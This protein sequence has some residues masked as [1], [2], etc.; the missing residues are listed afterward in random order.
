MELKDL[1]RKYEPIEKK[2]NLPSF[3]QLNIDFEIEK[4]TVESDFL[5]RV[6][7][8][9]MMDKIIGFLNFFEK[10]ISNPTGMPR[11]YYPFIKSIT[12]EDRKEMEKIYDDMGALSLESLELE[13]ITSEKA[14][15]KMVKKIYDCWEKIKQQ[16][17]NLAEKMKTSDGQTIRKEKS[18][19]G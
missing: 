5:L 9:I 11:V 4:I 12:V 3:E 15:A 8:K 1:K 17:Y 14:E 10:I 18:Y 7:R 2:Y 16:L 13:I 6:I 19:F